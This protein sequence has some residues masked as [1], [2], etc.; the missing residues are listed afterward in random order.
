MRQRGVG[1]IGAGPGVSA[2]HLPTLERLAGLFRVVHIADSG[3]GRS[4]ALGD[5]WG[6]RSSSGVTELLD[7]PAVDVVVVCSPPEQHAAHVMAA[8]AAGKRGVLCEKPLATTAADAVAVIEACRSTGT[9]LVVG[10]NHAFDPAWTK[11]KHHLVVNGGRPQTWTVTI[12]LPPNGRYHD[13]VSE[14]APLSTA[15]ARPAPDWAD[16]EV[17]ASIVRQLV[18]GLAI[19]DLP[20]LRDFGPVLS[21]VVFARPL[22]PIGYQI[23]LIAGEILVQLNAVMLPGGGDALW[24]LSIG[25][26]FDDI[27]IDFLP[28]FVHAGSA[29]VTVRRSG[30]EVTRYP[31]DADDG[32]LVE[33]GA[34]AQA[35]DENQPAE[36]DELL[37]DALFAIRIAD[38]AADAVREGMAS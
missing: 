26:A 29:A 2:L 18:L 12:S 9:V 14:T 35:L 3:S 5:R 17:S 23:G 33:W 37:E 4:T 38:A 32:Y 8:V 22:E 27:D 34:L 20:A 31:R 16:A 19:H 15:G 7:D 11:A 1:V 10:T 24:R 25:T 6:A 28:A 21:E 30:G 13:L 36:Y